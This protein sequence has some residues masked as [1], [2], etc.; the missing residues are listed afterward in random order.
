[1]QET[2]VDN[3]QGY[4]SEYL[5][6][7]ASGLQRSVSNVTSS[8]SSKSSNS[9]GSST[10]SSQSGR[11]PISKPVRRSKSTLNNSNHRSGSLGN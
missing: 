6:N 10:S 4:R 7:V 1:M 5:L 3:D 9:K 11:T 2:F 8:T